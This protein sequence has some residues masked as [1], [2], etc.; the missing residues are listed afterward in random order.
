MISELSPSNRQTESAAVPVMAAARNR[1]VLAGRSSC[2]SIVRRRCRRDPFFR[3]AREGHHRI[4]S[5]SSFARPSFHLGALGRSGVAVRRRRDEQS[6]QAEPERD[7]R[8]ARD[9]RT[10]LVLVIRCQRNARSDC[11]KSRNYGVDHGCRVVRGALELCRRLRP[12]AR[13]IDEEQ[14]A[15]RQRQQATS[16]AD[17]RGL[18]HQRFACAPPLDV[19]GTLPQSCQ[20][21]SAAIAKFSDWFSRSRPA[22]TSVV[23]PTTLPRASNSP[24]PEDPGEMGAVVC[25]K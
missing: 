1:C 18:W 15:T 11:L 8:P 21:E 3:G 17:T 19:I 16:N 7:V 23:T 9:G 5:T 12:C 2:R 20:N 22:N 4:E 13:G 24:P 6:S 25:T 10:L 14:R